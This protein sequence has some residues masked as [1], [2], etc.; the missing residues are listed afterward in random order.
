MQPEDSPRAGIWSLS[1][2]AAAAPGLEPAAQAL[3][4]RQLHQ[5]MG[6][7]SPPSLCAVLAYFVAAASPN[8]D[9]ANAALPAYVVSLLFFVGLLIRHEDQPGYWSWYDVSL[10]CDLLVVSCW[11]M[12]SF[13]FQASWSA[14]P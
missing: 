10:C 3:P 7:I 6:R 11:K 4:S 2:L 13:L 12:G 1:C 14:R 8:M 5:A 9:V